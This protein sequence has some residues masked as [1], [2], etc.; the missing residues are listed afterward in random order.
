M[1]AVHKTKWYVPGVS[2]VLGLAMLAAFWAG[3]RP[4]DGLFALGVMGALGLV[5]LV[6]GRSDLIRGLRGD[7]RD[8]YWERIDVDATAL[9]G[10]VLIAAIIGMCL[11]EWAH[12]RDGM[13]YAA[14][15]AVGGVGYVLSLALLRW[16]RR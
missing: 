9:T 11:W 3:D 14:L 7:G 5:A 6:G 16:R 4:G 1:T 13:P 2:L 8:E 15:G 12:G 10:H